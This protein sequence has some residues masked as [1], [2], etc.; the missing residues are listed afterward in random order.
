MKEDTLK[1]EL[2]N[3]GAKEEEIRTV[4]YESIMTQ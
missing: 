4:Q 1:E 3:K 2:Y